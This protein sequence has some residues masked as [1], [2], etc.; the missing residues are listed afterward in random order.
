MSENFKDILLRCNK[1][2]DWFEARSP[3]GSITNTELYYIYNYV[4]IFKPILLI[5]SGVYLGRSTLVLSEIMR[6]FG[7]VVAFNYHINKEDDKKSHIREIQRKVNNLD[8]INKKSEDGI[9]D[10]SID[11]NCFIIIDGPKPG[12]YLQGRNDWNVLMYKIS[13]ISFSC[14]FQHDIGFDLN[15][16]IMMECQKKYF[17]KYNYTEISKS[18][19][20]NHTFFGCED[21]TMEGWPNL[22]LFKRSSLI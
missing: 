1:N 21:K 12:G 18:F 22:G 6:P 9:D 20:L 15:R 13:Q 5:E 8:V 11:D 3:K 17:S 7:K 14:L 2:Y 16:N 10:I 4:N 19:L